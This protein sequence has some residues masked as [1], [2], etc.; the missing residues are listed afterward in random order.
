M[1]TGGLLRMTGFK[2]RW[3]NAHAGL[4]LLGL[5]SLLALGPLAAMPASALTVERCVSNNNTAYM[6]ITTGSGN[7]GTMV[8]SVAFNDGTTCSLS[9]I[10][11]GGSVLTAFS[12]GP[13][14]ALLPNRMRT[15]VLS[16]F[17]TNTVSCSTNFNPA[18][19]GGAGVFTLPGP[20]TRTVSTNA[21]FSTED[22]VPVSMADPNAATDPSAVPASVDVSTTRTITMF[23]NPVTCSGNTMAFPVGGVGN[24]FSD[25]NV[26]EVTNQSI[27]FDDTSGTRVGNPTSQPTRPDGFLLRGNC[28]ITST[29]QVIVFTATQGSGPNLGVAAAG[30]TADG[31]LMQT[32]TEGAQQNQIWF[33]PTRTPT[34]TPTLTPTATPTATPTSSPTSTPTATL[35]NSPTPAAPATPTESS[36]PSTPSPTPTPTALCPQTP[37]TGCRTAARSTLLIRTDDN[38]ARNRLVWKWVRGAATSQE[39]FGNPVAQTRYALCVYDSNGQRVSIEVP[40]AGTCS[41][42]DCWRLIPR[43]GYRYVDRLGSNGGTTR[44]VLKGHDADKAKIVFKSQGVNMPDPMLPY[45]PPVQVQLVN[46]ETTVCWEA[47]FALSDFLQNGS[48]RFKAK[49]RN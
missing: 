19:A 48:T 37:L 44:I 31:S 43:R 12:A 2:D 25:P 13:Y 21:A 35:T 36:T 7:I 40:P 16:G 33:T 11:P 4:A 29:C 26:G 27:T 3:W 23:G 45:N 8:T 5:V 18:G 20:G 10:G 49:K 9:E 28:S 46:D 17:T 15:Q 47:E 1:L 14:G 39:D 38:S 30:F 24:T 6:I 41:T 22:L 42:R 34:S 32:T